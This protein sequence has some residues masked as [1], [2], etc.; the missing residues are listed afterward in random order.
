M[1]MVPLH[2]KSHMSSSNGSLIE[3]I[4][5]KATEIFRMEAMLL[6]YISLEKCYRNRICT[7]SK[8]GF[9]FWGATAPIWA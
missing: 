7:F 6:L 4:K 1:F 8:I 2:T 3:V 9:F 5:P